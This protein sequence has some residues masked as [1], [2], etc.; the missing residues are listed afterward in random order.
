MQTSKWMQFYPLQTAGIG[1][2]AHLVNF[3]GV[4]GCVFVIDVMRP[5]TDTIAGVV[6]AKQYYACEMAGFSIPAAEHRQ[7]STHDLNIE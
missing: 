6:Y 1:G 4:C 3:Q 7:T 5:G 2:A